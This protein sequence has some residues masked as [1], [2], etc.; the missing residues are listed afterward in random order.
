MSGSVSLLHFLG[1]VAPLSTEREQKCS[2][3]RQGSIA[4]FQLS[5]CS[6]GMSWTLLKHL[7][8]LGI[9]WLNWWLRKNGSPKRKQLSLPG[10]MPIQS[11]V[12]F[13]SHPHSILSSHTRSD[14]SAAHSPWT[15]C[16]FFLSLS[17]HTF[18]PPSW[19][20]ASLFSSGDLISHIIQ[21]IPHLLH[22]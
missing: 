21:N 8:P 9:G 4:P 20:T 6:S 19:I 5:K 17:P 10:D 11:H 3:T 7:H 1:Q 16:P 14:H 13:S 12:F 18:F 15:L 22:S 2:C